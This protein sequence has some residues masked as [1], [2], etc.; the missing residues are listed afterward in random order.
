MLRAVLLVAAVA[1][2][3]AFAPT[4]FGLRPHLAHW[5]ASCASRRPAG[6]VS[7][8]AEVDGDSGAA[9]KSELQKLQERA[10]KALEQAEEAEKR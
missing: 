7:L 3:N 9:T 2:A 1:G 4:P 8:R 6:V 5:P 10:K